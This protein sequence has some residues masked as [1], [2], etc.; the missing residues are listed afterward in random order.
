M[1][2]VVAAP[3]WIATT[4]S[5]LAGIGSAL[6]AANAAAALP[7][8]AIVAAAEDEVSAAIAAVFGSHAQGYQALSAQMSAFHQQFVAGLTAGAGAYAATEAASTSPLGQL[9]GLI[10]APT[11]A[12]L[13]RPLIGNGTNGADGTGAPGGPGGLLLGNGGNGGSGAPGQVGGAGGAA[14]LLGNGGI[15]GKGGDAVAGNGAAGGAGGAGG[16]LLG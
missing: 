5:D 13:G 9:L 14:G 15:G 10:N 7:T 8:T 1:S 6:T 2:F 3:E 12:L 11:Q 4:A 16:W